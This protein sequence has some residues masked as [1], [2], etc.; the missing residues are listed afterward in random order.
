MRNRR[1]VKMIITK[2]DRCG[3]E[4]STNGDYTIKVT[5]NN[6]MLSE[7]M[8]KKFDLCSSCT[9]ILIKDFMRGEWNND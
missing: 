5:D 9:G 4:M 3:A 6:L 1:I 8:A 2:C 7:T